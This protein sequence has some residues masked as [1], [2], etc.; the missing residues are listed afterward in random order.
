MSARLEVADKNCVLSSR[1]FPFFAIGSPSLVSTFGG[2]LKSGAMRALRKRPGRVLF[3]VSATFCSITEVISSLDNGFCGT[4]FKLVLGMIVLSDPC[5]MG[6]CRESKCV[7]CLLCMQYF[8]IVNVVE[9][10]L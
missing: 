2:L 9:R 10:A 4:S 5:E 3:N 6:T 1:T 7:T 8:Q